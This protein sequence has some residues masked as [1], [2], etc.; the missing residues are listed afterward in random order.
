MPRRDAAT[1]PIPMRIFVVA[2]VVNE[3]QVTLLKA[4]RTPNKGD[5]FIMKNETVEKP[6]PPPIYAVEPL[7][8]PH[9]KP[10]VPKEE[11]TQ[12]QRSP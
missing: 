1:Q 7:H 9:V 3:P 8:V 6:P 4:K 12:T 5:K 2:V 11:D 10:Q